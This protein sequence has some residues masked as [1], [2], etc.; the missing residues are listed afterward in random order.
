VSRAQPG[1]L[2][3]IGRLRMQQLGVIP[4]PADMLPVAKPIKPT[5]ERLRHGPVEASD[6]Q[7]RDAHGGIGWPYRSIDIV[8]AMEKR[9]AI[10]KAMRTA[11][12]K[13]REDF[14]RAQLDPLKAF[15]IARP[16]GSTRP[17]DADTVE[18]ARRR[19][20]RKLQAVGGIASPAGSCLWYVVGSERSLKDWA[21]AQGWSGRRVSQ[22]VAS[23]I[24][25]AALGTLAA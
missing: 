5:R 7:E 11:A 10:S 3:Q 17:V 20:W 12:D 23:G 15:D 4:P 8:A 6:K 22:E 1:E 24:L 19:V 2:E 21:L 16:P 13:F 9:G 25:I 14:R 18:A